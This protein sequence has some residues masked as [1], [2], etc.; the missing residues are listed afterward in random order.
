MNSDEER[1][2]TPEDIVNIGI[3][4]K[5]L[6]AYLFSA[7]V[8]EIVKLPFRFIG[9]MFRS[10]QT[11]QAAKK[12]AAQ[13]ALIRVEAEK[14]T[15]EE[16]HWR[17]GER[18]KAY[19]QRI[20]KEKKQAVVNSMRAKP[21]MPE[22]VSEIGKEASKVWREEAA[23]GLIFDDYLYA[24]EL[25]K[26][27]EGRAFATERGL[28]PEVLLARLQELHA[29]N[30]H[31]RG[32][33]T[34]RLTPMVRKALY[35]AGRVARERFKVQHPG[36]SGLAEVNIQD[37]LEGAVITKDFVSE[38]EPIWEYLQEAPQK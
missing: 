29:Q 9:S 11:A 37:L 14:K 34:M 12:Q 2:L 28:D 19:L 1:K 16:Y 32:S 25:F 33:T 20:E 5:S 35:S 26:T 18:K 13:A 21:V 3:V 8:I 31:P 30:R 6:G 38:L 4:T 23:P 27:T 17:M 36:E 7:L 15:K 24:W 10:S 22:V